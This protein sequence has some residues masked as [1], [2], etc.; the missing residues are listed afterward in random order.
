[1]FDKIFNRGVESASDANEISNAEDV[2]TEVM[3]SKE[4]FLNRD[5]A[6]YDQSGLK[7]LGISDDTMARY[8]E[9]LAGEDMDATQESVYQELRG[10]GVDIVQNLLAVPAEGEDADQ[11]PSLEGAIDT[12]TMLLFGPSTGEGILTDFKK[13]LTQAIS[14]P[15]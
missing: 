4:L 5:L 2:D 6:S 12:A 11:S 1:M 15:E 8:Q 7:Q 10:L 3:V 13:D 14:S 9:L